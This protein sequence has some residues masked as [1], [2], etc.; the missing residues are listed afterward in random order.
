MLGRE[1]RRVARAL[2]AWPDDAFPVVYLASGLVADG[3]GDVG[4]DPVLRVLRRADRRTVIHEFEP[5]PG[6]DLCGDLLDPDTWAEIA[7]T[8]IRSAVC[9]NLLEHLADRQRFVEL[10]SSTLPPGGRLLVT[11]PGRYPYH[12]DPIDTMYRP[13]PD[14][15]SRT[16]GSF[17]V[18]SADS[19]VGLPAGLR[20]FRRPRDLLAKLGKAL[21]SRA[22]DGPVIG[23]VRPSSAPLAAPSSALSAAPSLRVDVL[24]AV[25][26]SR[27]SFAELV[28]SGRDG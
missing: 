23:P 8:G 9:T 18:L 24:S 12:P 6:V 4:H 5:A 15:L 20:L 16:F 19:V 28:R 3:R 26:P 14:Q 2:G 13:S 21:R 7:A 27:V 1:A 10:V 22:S 25:L 11:V 17:E